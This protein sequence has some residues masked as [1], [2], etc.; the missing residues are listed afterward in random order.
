MAGL[1]E[2][3]GGQHSSEWG[4][5][6]K[7]TSAGAEFQEKNDDC[8]PTEVRKREQMWRCSYKRKQ[9]RKI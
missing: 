6:L 3:T 9:K 2:M 8:L 5:G 1:R 4:K 7:T